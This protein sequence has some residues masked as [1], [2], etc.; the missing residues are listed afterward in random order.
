MSKIVGLADSFDAITSKRTYRDA[1]TIE[2]A[3]KEIEKGL[4]TQFD[5]KIGRIFINS[6]IY[7]LWDIIMQNSPDYIGIYGRNNLEEYGAAAVG[8][9]IR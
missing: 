9:L 2:Q 6:D 1:R 7:L 5:E 3:I 4:G 8:T